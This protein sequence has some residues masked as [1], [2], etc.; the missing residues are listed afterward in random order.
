VRNGTGEISLK[1]GPQADHQKTTANHS[2]PTHA[3]IRTVDFEKFEADIEQ[4]IED[5]EPSK[6]FT[7]TETL[8]W[9]D[10]TW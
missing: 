6:S 3:T 1:F 8:N 2:D 9:I 7:V 10:S 5:F 4:A